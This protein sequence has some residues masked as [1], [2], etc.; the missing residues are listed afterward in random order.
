M[1]T[2]L[3]QPKPKP[4]GT[5]CPENIR[6]ENRPGVRFIESGRLDAFLREQNLWDGISDL[7]LH[8]GCGQKVFEGYVNIDY[9]SEHHA[10]MSD[11]QAD[12]FA[13]ILKLD[14]SRGAVAEIRLHH[15]FEHF[16]RVTGL[17]QIFRWALWLKPGGRL[18]IETP[19]IEGMARTFLN[20]RDHAVRMGLARHIAGDQSSP[21][22]YH[23]E[24]WWPERYV[25]TL[26]AL[27]FR[28]EA[29]ASER[30][31]HT[32]FLS[33]VVV[34]AALKSQADPDS[35]KAALYEILRDS[36]INATE[37]PT[38]Q[39]WKTQLDEL[40]AQQQPSA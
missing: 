5:L 39:V 40:L 15:V 23:F 13:D 37:E 4:P 28:I 21:W 10:V 35:M 32:P 30:W 33:N 9:P 31:E 2:E 24:H 18:I 6:K 34:V 16:N 22:G 12:V 17:A 8:L 7:K 1:I 3:F 27:N 20:T 29:V 36:M 19:D 11:I 25:R 38:F 14:C 26:E